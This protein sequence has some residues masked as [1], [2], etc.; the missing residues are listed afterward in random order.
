[1]KTQLEEYNIYKE[2]QPRTIETSI[3]NG[4]KIKWASC[5][6]YKDTLNQVTFKTLTK[7]P[8]EHESIKYQELNLS[9]MSNITVY[10]VTIKRI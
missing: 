1:M 2:S 8:Y 5:W 9:P 4:R 10:E 7:P 3:K 6:D